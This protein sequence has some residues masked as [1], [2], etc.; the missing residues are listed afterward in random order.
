MISKFAIY[1]RAVLR[2]ENAN[3]KRSLYSC[4]GVKKI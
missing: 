3:V 4:V 2:Q 1:L